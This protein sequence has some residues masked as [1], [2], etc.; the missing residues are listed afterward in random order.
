LNGFW[1]I[2]LKEALHIRRDPTTL[3]F[4][5]LIPMVQ[6][7]LFGYAIDFDVRH[8]RTM[9]VDMDRTRESRD[10]IASL[11]NTEYLAMVGYL[12][13]PDSAEQALRRSDAHVA[14]IVPPDFARR[15]RT[16]NPAVVRVLL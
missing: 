3:V 16:R 10:Y 5:L 14:V 1:S 7:I 4:A 15:Y 6:M 2:V 13:T 8:I 9:V 11:Q 12:P